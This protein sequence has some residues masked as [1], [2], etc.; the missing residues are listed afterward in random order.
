M[1][2]IVKWYCWDF[3]DFNIKFSD[4]FKTFLFPR[5]KIIQVLDPYPI[6][7][8]WHRLEILE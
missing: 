2:K 7:Y 8:S 4:G 5:S 3:D 6:R 1:R